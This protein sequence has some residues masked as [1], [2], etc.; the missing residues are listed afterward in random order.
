MTLERP[1]GVNRACFRAGKGVAA[2]KFEQ[3][4]RNSWVTVNVTPALPNQIRIGGRDFPNADLA[5]PTGSKDPTDP[6][7]N[8]QTTQLPQ[9]QTL[10]TTPPKP[11]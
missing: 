1:T 6:P 9:I 11:T 3:D 2:P 4:L 8:P 7:A 5:P 10:L